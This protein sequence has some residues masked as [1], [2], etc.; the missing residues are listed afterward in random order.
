MV[1]STFF[2]TRSDTN[3]SRMFPLRMKW[4]GDRNECSLSKDLK[5][6]GRGLF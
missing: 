2:A 3:K 1:K 4:E 5:E 6:D